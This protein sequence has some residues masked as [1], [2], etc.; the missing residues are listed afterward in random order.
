METMSEH[1]LLALRVFY[2]ESQTQRRN[3]RCVRPLKVHKAGK[4]HVDMVYLARSLLHILLEQTL[5]P[6][7]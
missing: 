5:L 7:I 6:P 4:H 1:M 3:I 2:L